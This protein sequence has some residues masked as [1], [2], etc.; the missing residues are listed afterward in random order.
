MKK[1]MLQKFYLLCLLSLF[2]FSCSTDES[3]ET[4]VLSDDVEV[5]DETETDDEDE[6]EESLDLPNITVVGSSIDT[7]EGLIARSW[8]NDYV[9]FEN[10]SFNELYEGTTSAITQRDDKQFFI[11]EPGSSTP[12]LYT[13][14]TSTMGDNFYSQDIYFPLSLNDNFITGRRA[15]NSYINTFYNENSQYPFPYAMYSYNRVTGNAQDIPLGFGDAAFGNFSY[16]FID[17]YAIILVD[18][19]DDSTPEVL[20]KV[21]NL[22]TAEVT[23]VD[24]DP[25]EGIIV[26]SETSELFLFID[27]QDDYDVF[28]LESES[29]TGSGNL[30]TNIVFSTPFRSV[31]FLNNTIAYQQNSVLFIKNMAT[32][33]EKIIQ[34]S[35]LLISIENSTGLQLSFAP[36]AIVDLEKEVL[37]VKLTYNDNGT[38]KGGVAFLDF[39][40]NFLKIIETNDINPQEIFI[41]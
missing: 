15:A 40:L 16:S 29:I 23:T 39:D 5:V 21:V 32:G 19:D 28:D 20:L 17:E 11:F 12:S 18:D 30:D 14:D 2:L 22:Q 13:Y 7:N 41:N 26:N 3:S 1:N 6:A 35:D 36:T 24:F 33:D 31:Q 25:Y 37:I 38:I 10:M 34:P 9:T 4:P 8:S 27:D